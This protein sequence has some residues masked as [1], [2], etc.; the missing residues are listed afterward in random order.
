MGC[1]VPDSTS[2]IVKIERETGEFPDNSGLPDSRRS[3]TGTIDTRSSAGTI[4][5]RSS[6]GTID[7]EG[8][9]GDLSMDEE[10]SVGEK[11]NPDEKQSIDI[12][13]IKCED[14]RSDDNRAKK[15]EKAVQWRKSLYQVIA[16]HVSV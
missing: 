8:K 2:V 3:S 5:R 13:N 4:D 14:D 6:A 9:R 16:F 11:T 10:E 1:Q 7:S 15:R 12:E